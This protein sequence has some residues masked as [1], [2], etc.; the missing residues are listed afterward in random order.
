VNGLQH[1]FNGLQN[2]FDE[3]QSSFNELKRNL[4]DDEDD[5]PDLDT[6]QCQTLLDVA[7]FEMDM[8]DK[9]SRKKM[10]QCFNTNIY[11]IIDFA[12]K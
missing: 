5:L 4:Q 11:V 2:S 6:I 1:S 9:A 3:L 10:V 7:K 12:M 8:Q